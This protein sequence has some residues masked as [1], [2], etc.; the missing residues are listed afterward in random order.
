MVDKAA[1]RWIR[2]NPPSPTLFEKRSAGKTIGSKLGTPARGVLTRYRRSCFGAEPAVRRAAHQ[3][4]AAMRTRVAGATRA[5]GVRVRESVAEANA[6]HLAHSNRT[7][8]VVFRD[9]ART[10]AR[11]TREETQPGNDRAPVAL[12]ERVRGNPSFLLT[13]KAHQECLPRFERI[14]SSRLVEGAQGA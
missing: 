1:P 2:E 11:W 10:G 14:T 6:R 5:S 13:D 9:G 3:R 7:I 8:R 4:K 12:R